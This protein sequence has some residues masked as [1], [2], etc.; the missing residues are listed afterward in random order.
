[1]L[2]QGGK[3]VTPQSR[4]KVFSL[5]KE[6]KDPQTGQSL[7]RIEK[8][9]C[10]V[11]IDR[12]T[13]TMS[14]GTL[15]NLKISLEGVKADSLQIRESIPASANKKQDDS[16]AVANADKSVKKGSV[17]K[18]KEANPENPEQSIIKKNDW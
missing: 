10:D 4:Y 2:S 13:P 9:C 17:S 6:L 8:Y 5:G 12:V 3:S 11:V 1:V 16:P 7:G 15:E 14:Y 18:S